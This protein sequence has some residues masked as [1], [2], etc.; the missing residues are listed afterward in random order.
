MPVR[1]PH[2]QSREQH[3]GTPAPLKHRRP[4]IFSAVCLWCGRAFLGLL[5]ALSAGLPTVFAA[6]TVVLLSAVLPVAEAQTV[7]RGPYLQGGTSSGVIIR[8]RTDVATAS[9]VRYGLDPESLTLSKT[10]P[11]SITDEHV[12]QLTGLSADVQYFY[13]AGTSSATLAGGDS[14]H[15]FV[16]SST[17]GTAKPTRIWVIGDSGT[18]KANARAVRDA[19]LNFTGSRNPDLWIMLGDNAYPNGTDAEYQA[20]VFDTYPQVLTKTVLWPAWETEQTSYPPEEDQDSR[21]NRVEG[22]KDFLEGGQNEV[23]V[24]NG[25]LASFG[26]LERKGHTSLANFSSRNRRKGGAK[27]QC[28]LSHIMI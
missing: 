9:V 26:R 10:N 13:S 12:V 14:D 18:A 7:V 8:W 25:A 23:S 24:A 4:S 3:P 22:I 20:A 21:K 11:H 19:F 5:A 27:V 16:T 1:T 28:V 6:V 17:P 15:F 2:H